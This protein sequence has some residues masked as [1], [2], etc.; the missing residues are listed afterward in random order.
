MAHYTMNTRRSSKRWWKQITATAGAGATDPILLDQIT[1]NVSVSVFPVSGGT[2]L[3]EI[4]TSPPQD[5][6]DGTANWIDWASGGVT[7]DTNDSALGPISGV[8]VTA[9]TQDCVLEVM[10]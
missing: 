6:I 9:T 2:A 4:S 3:V 8:R 10:A 5:V 1:N 7:A